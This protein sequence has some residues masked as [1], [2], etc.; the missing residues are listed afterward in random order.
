MGNNEAK[1][2]VYMKYYRQYVDSKEAEEVE[3]YLYHT[4]AGF[5][6]LVVVQAKREGYNGNTRTKIQ[7]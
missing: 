7:D 6:S 4:L 2:E 1:K 3:A 5:V